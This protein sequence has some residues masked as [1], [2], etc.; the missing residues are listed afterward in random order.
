MKKRKTFINVLLILFVVAF[1]VT[2]L[3]YYGKIFLNR[4]FSFAPN[5]I[6]V[7]ERKQLPNYNWKLK[8]AEWNFF[9]FEKSKGRVTF[10][11]FWASWRLPSEAE[12]ASIQKLYNAYGNEIDFYIITDEERPPVEAFMN[13][14]EFTFPLTYLIIGEPAPLAINEPPYSYLIDKEGYIVIEKDGIANWNSKTVQET[15]D[16]LISQ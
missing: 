7:S 6:E 10:V 5:V 12:L 11:N 8:D 13:E 16:Y 15:I 4:L 2:P 1:F 14:H 9:N 3:G